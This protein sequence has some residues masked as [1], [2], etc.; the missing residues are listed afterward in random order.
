MRHRKSQAAGFAAAGTVLFCLGAGGGH[1]WQLLPL[2]VVSAAHLTVARVPLA[3][4]AAAGAAFAA[5]S[6]LGWDTGASP[7]TLIAATNV[8]Y[9][10][11]TGTTPARRAR[12][13]VAALG[14]VV[15]G[16]AVVALSGAGARTVV[17]GALY[18]TAVL[19]L[20]LWWAR[21]VLR[22]AEL[23][24]LEAERARR[25]ERAAMA[26]DLHDV[27]AGHLSAIAL[28]SEAALAAARARGADPGVLPG[29][30][31]ASVEALTQ[32]RTMITLMRSGEAED[33]GEE[34]IATSPGLAALPA[35][36]DLARAAGL[37]VRADLDVAALVAALPESARA[38][39]LAGQTVHRVL[40]EALTNARKH[41]APG[42]VHVL[43]RVH[44]R[45][46]GSDL[47]LRVDSP[48]PLRTPAARPGGHGGHGLAGMR[49]RADAL[50][51]T[52]SAAARADLH[53]PV[54]RVQL[55]VPL[56]AAVPA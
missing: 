32:M 47:D 7:V 51:A 22:G 27:V 5:D 20:P 10:A 52:F 53:P 56:P 13:E 21:D 29:V 2:L 16:A 36:V 31:A 3:T 46:D 26:R 54:W 1:A 45:T 44:A 14:C 11:Y 35:A 23:A 25:A 12:L 17:A 40:T 19:A 38:H 33:S 34:Q 30:R 18:L 49:E 28:Q 4:A 41:A 6:L 43:V 24:R 55:T 48:L 50:G 37:D 42:P 9:W 8:L 15:A 39:P